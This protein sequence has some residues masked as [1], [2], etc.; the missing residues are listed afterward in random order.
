MRPHGQGVPGSNLSAQMGA[1]FILI[2]WTLRQLTNTNLISSIVVVV[3]VV[4]SIF[5]EVDIVKAHGIE[6]G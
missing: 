4:V 6:F 2:M 1:Y 5:F 3:V